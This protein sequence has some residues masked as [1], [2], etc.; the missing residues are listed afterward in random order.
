MCSVPVG[1]GMGA[2][3]ACVRVAVGAEWDRFGGS[4]EVN[5][6]LEKKHQVANPSFGRWDLD[7][8]STLIFGHVVVTMTSF[9]R[10]RGCLSD[11]YSTSALL[12]PLS[13]FWRL[14]ARLR[15]DGTPK[16]GGAVGSL[17]S[18]EHNGTVKARTARSE[19]GKKGKSA[20]SIRWGEPIA[21]AD[22]GRGA[23]TRSRFPGGTE[24]RA[25]KRRRARNREVHVVHD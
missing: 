24:L 2:P 21:R 5:N 12:L 16:I 19:N 1:M 7:G 17:H 3:C 25:P 18:N 10:W 4:R 15:V 23:N 8:T 13:S 20:W 22:P 6:N 9:C 14:G 11:S